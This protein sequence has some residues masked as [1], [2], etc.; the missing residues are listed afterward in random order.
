M[1]LA[2]GMALL[3]TSCNKDILNLKNENAYSEDTYFKNASECNQGVI[4]CYSVL[5]HQ[6]MISRDWSYLFDLMANEATPD[7]ALQGQLAD[8]PRFTFDGTNSLIETLW[9]SL[10]RMI[11]R[12]NLVAEK[13][14]QWQPLP[15]E[16]PLKDQYLGESYFLKGFAEFYQAVLW[17]RVPLRPDWASR[18]ETDMPRASL[19]SVWMAVASDLTKASELLPV[20]YDDTNWGRATRGAAVAMLGKMYLFRKQYPEAAAQFEKLRQAPYT[21]SLNPSY[22]LLFQDVTVKNPE[23]VF[24]VM[25]KFWGTGEG[26]AYYMFGGQENWGGKAAST[27]RSMEYGFNDWKNVFIS[28][29]CV[30]A[31]TY[32]DEKGDTYVDPRAKWT[33]YGNAASGG[34]IDYCNHCDGGAISYDF[35]A[36]QYRWRKYEEYEYKEKQGNPDGGINTQVVRYADVLLMLAECKI[37]QDQPADALPLIN[38]VRQRSGA[39]QYTTLGNKDQAF[40]ILRRERRLELCGEEVRWFDLVRW[41]VAKETINAEKTADNGTQPFQD[42]NVLLP[43]PQDE[44]DVNPAVRDDI[45]NNWN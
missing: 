30:K 16:E 5:L 26:N 14:G 17:G 2:G 1:I 29:A 43:I 32:P 42:R 34:D 15:G 20:D 7:V 8:L 31:F 12:C 13:V 44:K 45:A 18:L 19:D 35:A 40:K 23:T 37:M 22:D 41:G 6:G 24:E 38:A 25:H 33:F 9:K 28:T 11:L 3:A 4:A 36:N 27:G 10:Y 39:F 21:Y